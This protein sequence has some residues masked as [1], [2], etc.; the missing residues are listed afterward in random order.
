VPVADFLAEVGLGRRVAEVVDERVRAEARLAEAAEVDADVLE[1]VVLDFE[2]ARLDVDHD[3][4]RFAQ[5]VEQGLDLVVDLGGLD[6]RPA[7]RL[8]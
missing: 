3:A 5:V 4:G 1:E 7:C 6:R 8:R 2:E